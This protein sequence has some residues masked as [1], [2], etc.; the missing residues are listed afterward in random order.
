MLLSAEF[1]FPS[2]CPLSDSHIFFTELFQVNTEFS[3]WSGTD[4]MLNILSKVISC[5]NSSFTVTE[6]GI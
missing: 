2:L 1:C 6:G 5:G 3:G 4:K